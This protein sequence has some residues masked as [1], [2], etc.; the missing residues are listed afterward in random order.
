MPTTAE[1]PS[2]RVTTR[3]VLDR[4]VLDRA[5]AAMTAR[6]RAEVE[7]LE[8]AL[9]WAHAH[10]AGDEDDAAGWRS[11]A[12]VV[13]GSPWS[14]FGQRAIP[15][16]GAGTPEVAEFAVMELAAALNVSHE[17]ALSLVGDVLDLAHRLPRTWVLV[18]ELRV[19]AH[20]GREAARTSRDLDVAAAR[21]ADR[22]LSWQPS[23][24]NPHRIGVLI[25]EARLYA[26]PDRAVADHDRAMGQRK[27]ECRY[28]TGAPGTGEAWLVLDE[29]DLV[30]FDSTVGVMADQ[31]G[32]LG[33]PGSLDIRRAHAVGIL[34]D[35]QQALDLLAVDPTHRDADHD[36]AVVA[37]EDIAHDAANPFRRP[38]PQEE[39][40]DRSSGEVVL[41]FH[42][43]D[44]DL[45]DSTMPVGSGG[46]AVS[47]RLGPVLMGRLQSWLLTAAKVTIKP[48][49]DLVTIAPV[50][51]HD[52]PARMAEAV[53]FR[54]VT[55]VYPGCGRAAESCDLDHIDPYVPP[56]EGGPPGQTSPDNLAPLCRRHHRAKTFAAF[57]YRRLSDGSYE[58]TLPSGTRVLTDPITPRPRHGSEPDPAA[59]RRR[60]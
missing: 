16:A 12:I 57:S 19:P 4:S 39:G 28:G 50:D 52:P 9:A 35:P 17:A 1:A 22:L 36:P 8:S 46:V 42:V 14:L 51:A 53:R 37:A 55:C 47:P 27:V 13:P 56:D 60:P 20:L 3:P 49:V 31:I 44:R 6:R 15:L 32:A 38:A 48:V 26:D 45:L 7:V 11:D 58:W 23:R 21:H 25:H 29:A 5:V 59:Q 40:R 30:A 10:V 24:L 18:R 43:T 2:A 41:V 54:D 33:H 34:A